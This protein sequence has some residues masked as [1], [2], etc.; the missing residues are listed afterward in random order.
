MK[1]ALRRPHLSDAALA[2]HRHRT[3]VQRLSASVLHVGDWVTLGSVN[4]LLQ[5]EVD[6]LR[7]AGSNR[8]GLF[9]LGSPQSEMSA[10]SRTRPRRIKSAT[11][12]CRGG[13]RASPGSELNVAG[14]MP[15]RRCAASA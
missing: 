2:L 9:V 5:A 12:A 15:F 3:S 13:Q 7:N 8:G 4:S 1:D 6:K 14:S 11:L 10:F